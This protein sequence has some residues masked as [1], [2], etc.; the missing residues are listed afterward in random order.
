LA[1]PS[2][3]INDNFGHD[4]GDDALLDDGSLLKS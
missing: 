4:M 1:M 3:L 2:N